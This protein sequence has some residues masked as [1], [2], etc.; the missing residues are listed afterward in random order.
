MAF[1]CKLSQV[2][3][4]ILFD[5]RHILSL[6]HE[7]RSFGRRRMQLGRIHEWFQNSRKNPRWL[8][9]LAFCGFPPEKTEAKQVSEY[10]CFRQENW[11]IGISSLFVWVMCYPLYI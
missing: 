9:T 8:S 10:D 6:L 7:L 11:E 3:A 4:M 5:T 2:A 1:V